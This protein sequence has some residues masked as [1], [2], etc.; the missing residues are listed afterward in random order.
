MFVVGKM[1]WGRAPDKPE[2]CFAAHRP[3]RRWIACYGY[4][5]WISPRWR[6][7]GWMRGEGIGRKGEEL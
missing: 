3:R 6:E 7:R 5:R 2:F 1:G 4:Y